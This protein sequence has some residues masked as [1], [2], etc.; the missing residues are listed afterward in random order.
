MA[1]EGGK[2]QGVAFE[3][4]SPAFPPRRKPQIGL[5]WSGGDHRRW[6][7]ECRDMLAPNRKEFPQFELRTE[8]LRR[9]SD[10]SMQSRR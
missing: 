2:E 9:K 4:G 3:G 8:S 10:S 1:V 5:T 6:L 7:L